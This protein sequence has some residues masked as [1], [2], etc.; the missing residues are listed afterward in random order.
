MVTLSQPA[1]LLA[2]AST[3]PTLAST[4]AL[5]SPWNFHKLSGL[6]GIHT[7]LTFNHTRR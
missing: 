4:E 7:D 2:L 1:T 3:W 5:I 6:T